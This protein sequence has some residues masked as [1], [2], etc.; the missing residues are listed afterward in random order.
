MFDRE[1]RY[2][3]KDYHSIPPFSSFLPGIAG[4][5][6]IP[7]WCYYNNRGQAVCSFGAQ[8]KD[9][10]ILEFCPANTAYRDVSRTG[11]RTFCKVD[12]EFV[13]LFTK[14]CSMYIGMS[15]L[16]LAS[17]EYGVEASVCYFGVPEERTAALARILTV[18]N[19]RETD[20]C[21]EML[22][23]LAAIVPY[24][25]GQ[26]VLKNMSNLAT[27]WMQAEDYEEGLA[28]FRTRASMEDTARV[29]K[30]EGGNFCIA[31]DKAGRRIAPIVQTRLVFGE[32]TSL[33]MPQGFL[34]QGLEELCTVKQIALNQFPCCFVPVKQQLKP[35]ECLTIYSLY[36]Q[37]EEQGQVLSLAEKICDGEWFDG[38]RSRAKAL[39]DDLCVAVATKTANPVFDAYCRQTYLD[40]L[41]R[42]GNPMFFRHKGVSKPFYIYSRKHGDPE[43][44]YNYFSLGRE[45]YAQ[46]NGNYRDVNQNR[47][48]DV[49][50]APELGTT[51]IHTF[52]DLIQTAIILLC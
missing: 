36:G 3:I 52:Y 27:A 9:H 39:V 29:T 42:G 8:D 49:L 25:V 16:E 30:V 50:F 48:C 5:M 11:F 17:E 23:G 7:V 20:V 21:L 12:G 13:E 10:A 38:K 45:Y 44:E 35:G 24:G 37:A 46:G 32:D 14:D 33:A 28:Y 40:N 47:R 22:D 19:M 51:N 4:P 26:D 41:L 34:R 15:E 1:G 43:R 18:R 6:G 31:I 2:L